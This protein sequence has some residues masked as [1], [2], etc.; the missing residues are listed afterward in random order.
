M[1]AS[2]VMC[3]SLTVLLVAAC[4]L[5]RADV[6]VSPAGND[7]NSGAK[8]HPFRTIQRARDAARQQIN[9]GTARRTPLTVLIAG[10]TYELEKSFELSARDSGTKDAPVCYRA[11]PGAEVRLAG[12]RQIPLDACKPVQD[13]AILARLDG[14]ARGHVLQVDLKALGITDFGGVVP[15][16]KRGELFFN[17]Q[18]LTL[19]RWPNQGFVK[20]VAVTGGRPVDVRGTV[21]DEI[22]KFTYDGDRPSRWTGETDAWLHGYWFWDWAEQY[23]KVAS[24]DTKTRTITLAPPYHCYGYRNGQHYYAVNLLAE[25][26]T[27]GEWYVDRQTGFLYFWPPS[28]VQQARV[29]FSTLEAPVILLKNVSHVILRD[30]IVETTRGDG[31]VLEG[32]EA[33][34][35]AGCTVRNAGATGVVVRGGARHGVAAC[36]VYQ[37]NAG[38]RISGGDR[39]TLTPAGNYA[40]NNH[41]HDF[42][43]LKR[44][45]MPAIELLGVGNRAEHNLIHDAPHWAISFHGNE[46][47]MEFNEIHDVCR[48]TGDVGVFYTGRDWTVRGNVIRYNFIHHV[49][50]PGACGAQGVYL[51][52]CASGTVVFGNVIYKT[53]RAMLIGGGRD[54]RIENNLMLRCTQSIDFDNRGLGWMKYHV[55]GPDAFMPARLAEIPYRQSPWCERYPQLLNL[56]QDDPGSPKANVVRNNAVNHC[57]PLSLAKEVVQFGT[58]ADNLTTDE[59]FGFEDAG[60]MDFRL[61]RDSVVYRRL[62]KFQTIPFEKIGLYRDEY[63]TS[64]PP[65]RALD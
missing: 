11:E 32:G 38:I 18:S 37:V 49:T 35:V 14:G 44:T 22:G 25:L 26:D 57:Q 8:D 9:Q 47:L 52:D 13:A 7:V 5:A 36:N 62:P 45:S 53:T 2:T 51:D 29:V 6:Y 50:G 43:R 59:D 16:G 31:I 1:R 4:G 39:V 30:L 28:P 64:L 65:R 19:A 24:L 41:I 54:N 42:A 23:H 10:G 40:T 17:D 56:L 20:I 48:E 3:W 63:R 15:D 46:H 55:V 27:P 61:R 34:L 21:G 33:N 60:K 12:G 58:V